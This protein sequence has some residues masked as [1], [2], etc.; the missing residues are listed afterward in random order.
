MNMS[1]RAESEGGQACGSSCHPQLR[2]GVSLTTS[3]IPS[4]LRGGRGG[5]EEAQLKAAKG[6]QRRTDGADGT[7][8]GRGTQKPLSSNASLNLEF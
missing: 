1:P 4:P 6:E 3:G 8:C 5:E 7:S 2:A